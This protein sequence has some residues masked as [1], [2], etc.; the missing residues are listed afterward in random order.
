MNTVYEMIYG[1]FEPALIEIF[2]VY[3]GRYFYIAVNGRVVDFHRK[4]PMASVIFK[5]SIEKTI[6]AE[7]PFIEPSQW[8]FVGYRWQEYGDDL[9]VRGFL[10][11][12][13]NDF[14]EYDHF[15]QC[16]QQ[17]G[18]AGLKTHFNAMGYDALESQLY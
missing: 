5:R 4:T 7:I 6:A 14:E 13:A 18:I 11:Y 2:D 8:H 17:H 10:N 3:D 1:S 12:D 16:V 15:L 9:E